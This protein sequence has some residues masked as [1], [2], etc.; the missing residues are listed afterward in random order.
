MLI[1]G[2]K[3]R[4]LVGAHQAAEADHVCGKYCGETA[5]HQA[6]QTV[7]YLTMRPLRRE[8]IQKNPGSDSGQQRPFGLATEQP[9]DQTIPSIQAARGYIAK[10][11]LTLVGLGTPISPAVAV[12]Y[13]SAWR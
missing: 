11:W 12:S 5:F 3:R 9:T 7:R 13:Q 1:E 2:S 8:A 10:A 4:G 6:A